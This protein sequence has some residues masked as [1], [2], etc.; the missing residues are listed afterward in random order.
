M[1]GKRKHWLNYG[2]GLEKKDKSQ[3]L[4]DEEKNAGTKNYGK[5]NKMYIIPRKEQVASKIWTLNLGPFS[6]PCN[7]AVSFLCNFPRY[8]STFGGEWK[9]GPPFCCW[10]GSVLEM[11]S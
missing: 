5:K 8:S 2:G 3:I 4:Q 9:K 11:K 7:L 1:G 10:L 6:K